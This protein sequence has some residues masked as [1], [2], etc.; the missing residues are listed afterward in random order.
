LL[1]LSLRPL[2]TLLL[3]S[4]RSSFTLLSL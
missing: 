1:S 3:P 4:F 2:F